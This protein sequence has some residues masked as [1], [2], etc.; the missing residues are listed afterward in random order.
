M[1]YFTVNRGIFTRITMDCSEA[2]HIL[3]GL[4]RVENVRTL[5]SEILCK[6]LL[7]HKIMHDVVE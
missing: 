3:K 4:C 5:R 2:P 1:F 7:G 6:S